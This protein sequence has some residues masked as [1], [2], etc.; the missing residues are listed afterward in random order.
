MINRREFLGTTLGAGA[1]LAFTSDL[2]RAFQQ[3]GSGTLMQRAIPSSGEMLPVISFAPRPTAAPAPGPIPSMPGDVPAA[4]AVLKVFLDSGGRVVDVLHGGPIG[5]DA[6]RTAASE[7]GIQDTFLWTTPVNVMGPVQPGAPPPTPDAAAVRAHIEEKLARFKATRIDLAMVG[8]GG[9][10]SAQLAAL[11]EMKKA[12]RVRYIGVHTLLPPPN[13]PIGPVA[14]QLASIMRNEQIDFVGTDY[15]VGDRRVEE[16]I[17]PLARERKI[18]FLAYFTFDR[19]RIFKRAGNTPLPAWAAEFD[20]KTWAQFFLKYVLSHPAVVVARTGTTK[21]EHMLDNVGGGIGRLPN[22]AMRKRMA[23]LVDSFAPTPPPGPPQ[24]APQGFVTAVAV[25]AAVLDR[26][27]GEYKAA[28]GFTATFRRDGD[29]LIVKPGTNPEATLVARSETRFQDPR[30]PVFEFQ[31]DAQ[32]K[33]TGAILEQG[34]QRI[35]LE[36]K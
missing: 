17:L 13:F 29:K 28:S 32:G 5:E 23:Q 33:V 34:A 22:E 8:A 26:Y 3:S 20:A 27:V 2:A 21:A 9:D 14:T 19:G 10:A 16:T 36:R 31:L 15:S 4:K 6:G 25:P 30:G 35:P 11:R 1:S 12:G 18:G 7:L 24:Q